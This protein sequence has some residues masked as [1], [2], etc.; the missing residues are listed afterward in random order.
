MGLS[1]WSVN[2]VKH[3]WELEYAIISESLVNEMCIET[4]NELGVI[5]GHFVLST[6]IQFDDG[7][8]L[9]LV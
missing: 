4:V 9:V 5:G 7:S 1:S 3:A 8:G 2:E 6:G